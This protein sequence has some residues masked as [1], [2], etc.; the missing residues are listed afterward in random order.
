MGT[1]GE[2]CVIQS[3]SAIIDVVLVLEGHGG[4]GHPEFYQLEGRSDG[5]LNLRQEFLGIVLDGLL[6]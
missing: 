4:G 2:P 6:Y 3:L 5:G 1:N